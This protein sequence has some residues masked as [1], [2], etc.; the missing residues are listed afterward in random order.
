MSKWDWIHAGLEVATYLNAREAQQTLTE[1]KTATEIEKAHRTI[2]KAMKS[3]IFD[4]SRKIQL[5]EDQITAFPQQVYIVAKSLEWRLENGGLSADM[6]PDTPDME[7]YF[8]TEKKVSEVIRKSKEKLTKEQIDVSEQA[9]QYV[10]V[11][12]PMLQQA[13]SARTAQDSLEKTKNKW[14]KA[15]S[16]NGNNQLLAILG[17]LGLLP[18]CICLLSP[19]M[20]GGN[21]SY[22]GLILILGIAALIGSISLIRKG[23]EFAPQYTKLK[24]ERQTLE[25]QLMPEEEWEEVILMFG[26]LSREQFQN[27]YKERLAFLT[28]LLGNEFQKHLVSTPEKEFDDNEKIKCPYC[29]KK[30]KKA[31][32]ICGHCGKDLPE[33]DEDEGEED[34]YVEEDEDS[35][36]AS[37]TDN[38]LELVIEKINRMSLKKPAEEY[39]KRGMELLEKDE[40]NDAILEFV[41]VI[42]TSSPKDQ[43][44]QSAKKTLKEMGFTETDIRQI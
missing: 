30:T 10:V 28:P 27:I 4:I 36:D 35:S 20:G 9:V 2:L 37:S 29:G 32:I 7:Y 14:Q 13:I 41:K 6:F 38:A 39:F 22:A 11:E 44:Y 43:H 25:K 23:K 16:R 15:S 17:F 1:M 31:A 26:D 34:D 40:F 21:G 12:I 24:L 19:I 8:K 42:R 33:E 18:S 5:A 3:F